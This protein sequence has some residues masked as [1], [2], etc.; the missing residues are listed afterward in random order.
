LNPCATRTMVLALPTRRSANF[1]FL[2]F[3]FGSQGKAAEER[4]LRVPLH[5]KALQSCFLARFLRTPSPP[6]LSPKGARAQCLSA[7]LA[8]ALRYLL[9]SR[10]EKAH[11]EKKRSPRLPLK[12]PSHL[13]HLSPLSHF[14]VSR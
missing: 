12:K 7:L 5:C 6:A 8:A 10:T 13:S 9:L 2:G 3:F 1:F 4:K 14:T 11:G